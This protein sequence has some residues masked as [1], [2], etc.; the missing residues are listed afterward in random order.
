MI[1]DTRRIVF[2]PDAVREAV[3]FYRNSFPSNQPPGLVGPIFIRSV[4]PVVLGIS[5]Q[6]I[7]ARVFREVEMPAS[8]VAA[9]LIVYCRKM[10]IPLPRHGDKSVEA[11]GETIILGVQKSIPVEIGAN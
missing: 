2:S 1:L 11:H 10:R 9:M 5:I 7:G 3:K 4:N 6:A 8:E